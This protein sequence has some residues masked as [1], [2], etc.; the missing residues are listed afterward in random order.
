MDKEMRENIVYDLGHDIYNFLGEGD[1]GRLATLVA[2][3]GGHTWGYDTINELET[4]SD[5]DTE[6]GFFAE[7]AF[8]GKRDE[9]RVCPFTSLKAQVKGM[10]EKQGGIW[11]ITSCEIINIKTDDDDDDYDYY[12]I[13]SIGINENYFDAFISEIARLKELNQVELDS[14]ETQITLQRLIFSGAIT[15][16]ETFLMDALVS[17]VLTDSDGLKSFFNNFKFT[18]GGGKT[19]LKEVANNENLLEDIAKREMSKLMYHNVEK[20]AEIYRA[21]MNI[22]FPPIA[23]VTRDVFKRH[24]LVHRNGKTVEGEAVNIDKQMVD[25]VIQRIETFIIAIHKDIEALIPF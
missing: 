3:S 13:Q 4:W 5:D 25:D 1:D 9:D 22:S 7:I 14:P 8:S 10:A 11:H 15:C 16:L 21:V 18:E 23:D 12:F 17:W 24:D 2:E 19:H 20:I 6:V